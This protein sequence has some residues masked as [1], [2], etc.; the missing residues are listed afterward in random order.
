MESNH[1]FS[2][3]LRKGV[4]GA[5]IVLV[6][7]AVLTTAGCRGCRQDD[8]QARAD[9]QAEEEK[10][11][12]EEEKKPFEISP[13]SSRAI[14]LPLRNRCKPIS[15]ISWATRSRASLIPKVAT[16]TLS[17]VRVLR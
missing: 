4:H 11:K 16:T 8:P 10:K 14:G 15:T 3:W 13:G 9:K 5:L 7:L 1:A 12:K 17:A 2:M 6:S